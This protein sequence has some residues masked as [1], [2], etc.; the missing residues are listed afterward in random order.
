MVE[1]WSR[2]RRCHGVNDV[3]EGG[4]RAISCRHLLI[5]RVVKIEDVVVSRR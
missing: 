3:S 1:P 4:W 5:L 2:R